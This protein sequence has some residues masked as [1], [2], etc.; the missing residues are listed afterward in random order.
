[1]TGKNQSHVN[2]PKG[3]I[4]FWE[5]AFGMEPKKSDLQTLE[6]LPNR[7]C[8]RRATN[9]S[10]SSSSSKSNAMAW[11]S[12]LGVFNRLMDGLEIRRSTRPLR[13]VGG[14]SLSPWFTR[15]FGTIPGGCLGFLNHQQYGNWLRR[16][17]WTQQRT[18]R[19]QW[20][21]LHLYWQFTKENIFERDAHN[22]IWK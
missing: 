17:L 10:R 16:Y 21:Y 7:I 5:D 9:V 6:Q 4:L 15:S 20:R 8:W 13:L 1:M 12:L 14:S 11:P 2:K 22:T 18:T 3:S 19:I